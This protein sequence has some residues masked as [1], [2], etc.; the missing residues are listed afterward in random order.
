MQAALLP[1]RSSFEKTLE[2]LAIIGLVLSCVILLLNWSNLPARFPNHFGSSGEPNSWGGK[3][4]LI[5]YMIIAVS[6]FTGLTLA[7]FFPHKGNH[8]WPITEENAAAQY[9]ITR[10][11]LSCLKAQSMWLFVFVEW[12][13]IQIAREGT[14]G[15]GIHTLPTLLLM[16]FGTV[17]FYL[18]KG[19]RN[20]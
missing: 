5:I 10:S 4:I 11:C 8:V 12:R 6:L 7:G 19:Y 2:V 16:T 9:Q 3:S 15:L 14:G 20:R 1:P 13:T 18:W 17:A